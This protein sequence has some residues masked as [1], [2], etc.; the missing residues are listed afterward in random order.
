MR[1]PR[2]PAHGDFT[3][4][5]SDPHIRSRQILHAVDHPAVGAF[6]Y[7]GQPAVVDHQP[8]EIPPPAAGLGEHTD[9]VLRELGYGEDELADMAR[10]FVTRAEVFRTDHIQ[11]VNEQ[12]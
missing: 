10:G 9:E 2:S 1:L 4:V 5:A 12:A 6:T 11:N 3:E 8:Y 7:V